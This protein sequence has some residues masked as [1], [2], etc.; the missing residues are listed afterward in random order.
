MAEPL[1]RHDHL[2]AAQVHVGPARGRWGRRVATGLALYHL[3]QQLRAQLRSYLE[4]RAFTVTVMEADEVYELAQEWLLDQM[5]AAGQRAL[6]ARTV[7]VRDGKRLDHQYTAGPVDDNEVPVARRVVL[8][9]DGTRSQQVDLDGH[10]VTVAIHEA[11]QGEQR[12]VG[13]DYVYKPRKIV[14]QARDLAGRQAVVAFLQSIADTLIEGKRQPRLVVASRWGHWRNGQPLEP[15]ALESVV[16][17]GTQLAELLAD[18]RQFLDSEADYT[19]LSMPWHRGYLFH[20][21]PG[22]GKTS[23]ARAVASTLGLDVYWLPLSDLEGDTQLNE[24]IGS[25]P[26][27]CVL[28][29]EDIDVA[30]AATERDDDRKGIT[31]AGL[32]NSIDGIVTPRGLIV[33]MTTNNRAALDDALVRRGRVH[34]EVEMTY[35]VADQAARLITHLTGLPCQIDPDLGAG[36]PFPKVTAADIVGAVTEHMHDPAAGRLAALDLLDTRADAEL[37]H[38]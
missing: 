25:V 27:R 18:V 14:F 37:T 26:E 36:V 8:R 10:P 20:G 19:R 17:P 2:S 15:R 3:G 33:L 9:Y 21:P 31:L 4:N 12:S 32:L 13:G 34:C 6:M 22:V 7:Q 38:A 29:L 11:D 1:A 35:L 5:P 30:H 24:L 23:T 16:L 28:L